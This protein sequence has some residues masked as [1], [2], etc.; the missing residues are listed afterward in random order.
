VAVR[1][2]A[3]QVLDRPLIFD[4][5]LAVRIIGPEEAS[6]ISDTAG[7]LRAFFAVRSRYAEDQLAGAFAAGTRQYIIL[8][9]GLDTFA[10]RNPHPGLRVFEVDHPATQEW[11]RD[12]LRIADIP[13]PAEAVFAPV[14]FERDTLR[15]VL[16]QN[17]FNVKEPAFFSWLGVV[18]YLSERAFG[19]TMS[20]IAAMPKP[21][22]VVFDYAVARSSLHWME[23]FALDR[24]SARVAAAGEPFQ[25][26]FEPEQLAAKLQGMGFAHLEDL[27][28]KELNARYFAG[29]TDGLRLRSNLGRLMYARL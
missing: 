27:G 14:D 19:E 24:F 18:P 9:A 13:I 6:K 7:P 4:D 8:G 10:C 28:S 22:G 5:P 1:R 17:G 12:L 11:K 21:S 15:D 29:R 26:F 23:R 16:E 3:H 2:A 25:L 20:F